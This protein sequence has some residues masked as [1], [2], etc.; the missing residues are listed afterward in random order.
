MFQG[1]WFV[2]KISLNL[3]GLLR[4]HLTVYRNRG[5]DTIEKPNFFRGMR[6]NRPTPP[7]ITEAPVKGKER[8]EAHPG[9]GLLSGFRRRMEGA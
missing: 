4:L 5:R 3:P 6:K 8:A 7:P 2:A 1:E 9:G